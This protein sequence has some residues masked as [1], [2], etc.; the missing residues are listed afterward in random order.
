MNALKR[1]IPNLLTA[2]NL[3]GGILAIIFTLTGRIESAPW[4]IFMSA[5]F[6]L[7]SLAGFGNIRCR[8]C[9]GSCGICIAFYSAS[10]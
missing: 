10:V 4:C 9:Y 1:L 8:K 3:I 6:R 5:I 7:A 2:G